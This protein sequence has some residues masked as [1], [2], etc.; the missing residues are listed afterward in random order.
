MSSSSHQLDDNKDYLQAEKP[1]T[2]FPK[3]NPL[4]MWTA[5]EGEHAIGDKKLYTKTWLVR[6]T[7]LLK[8]SIA[9]NIGT[10]PMA[11]PAQK[12]SSSMALMTI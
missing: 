12:S 7:P 6:Y 8:H 4:M 5:T 3:F 9:N 1:T 11:N 2:P 10:S